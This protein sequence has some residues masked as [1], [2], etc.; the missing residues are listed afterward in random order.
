MVDMNGLK[1]LN[2]TYGHE[3]GNVAI[4]KT[5]S[6]ICDVFSHSPVYRFGGDEFVVIIKD[7]DYD[8]IEEKIRQFKSLSK[9]TTG[10]PWERVNAAIGYALYDHD[11]T[12]DDVFRRADHSMYEYKKE[13]KAEPQSA[14]A[15]L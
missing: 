6:L 11:D 10:E 14:R 4:K 9:E 8:S 5:C 12:V 15:A 1:L 2:D 7:R 3:K 13:M